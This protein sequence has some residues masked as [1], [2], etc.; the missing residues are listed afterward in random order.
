MAVIAPV[1]SLLSGDQSCVTATWTFNPTTDTCAPI[2]W[3]EYQD[4]SVQLVGTFIGNTI[5]IEGTNDGTNFV[6]LNNTLGAAATFTTNKLSQI[7]EASRLMRPNPTVA[8]TSTTLTA[9]AFLR[10]ANP[11]RT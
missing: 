4:R 7:V 3:Y 9:V 2:E 8:G 6:A 10:R 11:L 5:T 1:I